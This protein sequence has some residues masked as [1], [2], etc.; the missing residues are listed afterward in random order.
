[1][2]NELVEALERRVD[3]LLMVLRQANLNGE[4]LSAVKNLADA[5]IALREAPASPE[6]GEDESPYCPKC[7]AC[8]ESDCC[9]PS[10][11]KGG[12]GCMYPETYHPEG[13]EKC[14]CRDIHYAID[15]DCPK[16][17]HMVGQ[18]LPASPEPTRRELGDDE[19]MRKGDI[20]I[21]ILPD[22][23]TLIIE[24]YAGQPA[25]DLCNYKVYRP[26]RPAAQSAEVIDK[27]GR[28]ECATCVADV[29]YQAALDV[30]RRLVKT[31]NKYNQSNDG[32]FDGSR[33]VEIRDEF[34]AALA[35]AS[36]ILKREA[37]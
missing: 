30:L 35:A 12:E 31:G 7:G 28:G 37:K 13:G 36:A 9:R 10:M 18:P 1:M 27:R 14:T 21:E 17:G 20:A 4:E 34:D 32:D 22:P 11:C 16:H 24:G 29:R 6:G 3:I 8:G 26:A 19:I 33:C 15:S 23:H 25:G 2:S 5:V